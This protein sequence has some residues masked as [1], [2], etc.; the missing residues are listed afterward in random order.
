M[1]AK[2]HSVISR[3]HANQERFAESLN[4]TT[5]AIVELLSTPPESEREGE[6]ARSDVA[7]PNWQPEI[8]DC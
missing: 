7:A 5:E 2:Y 1:T 3:T 8:V 6:S 4:A